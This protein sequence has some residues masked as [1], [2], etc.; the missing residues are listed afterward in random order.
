MQMITGT[1]PLSVIGGLAEKGNG[2]RDGSSVAD[3]AFGTYTRHSSITGASV[4][5]VSQF[6]E[7]RQLWVEIANTS[8]SLDTQYNSQRDWIN[9]YKHTHVHTYMHNFNAHVHTH[10]PGPIVKGS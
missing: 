2:K 3:S 4:T 8:Y 9:Y 6:S 1:D 7:V 5:G 10:T